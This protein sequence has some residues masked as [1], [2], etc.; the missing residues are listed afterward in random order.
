MTTLGTSDNGS[1]VSTQAST[2]SI[3]AAPA[4]PDEM[5]ADDKTLL[6]PPIK[7]VARDCE[8]DSSCS[9]R[10]RAEVQLRPSSY[11]TLWFPQRQKP[12]P[13]I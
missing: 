12:C 2:A 13:L 3:P 6:G 7:L 1:A 11:R 5:D 9:L 8:G 10:R 4:A